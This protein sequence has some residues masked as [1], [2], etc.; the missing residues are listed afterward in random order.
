M[1][2]DKPWSCLSRQT[3]STDIHL[4]LSTVAIYDEEMYTLVPVHLYWPGAWKQSCL[5]FYDGCSRQVL[6]P[7]T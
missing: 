1:T 4:N 3:V 6:Q 2:T 5:H 7:D